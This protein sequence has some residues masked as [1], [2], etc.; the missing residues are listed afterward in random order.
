MYNILSNSGKRVYGV[1][2]FMVETL[3]DIDGIPLLVTVAPGSTVIVANTSKKYILTRDRVWMPFNCDSPGGGE[4]S[5]EQEI[6][7]EGGDLEA[8]ISQVDIDYEG[9]EV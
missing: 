2:T 3:A 9:G 1:K 7:Y 6:I 5:P 4:N 8:G